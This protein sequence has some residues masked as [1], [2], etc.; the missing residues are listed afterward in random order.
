VL[1][2]SEESTGYTNGAVLFSPHLD[3]A[4]LSASCR[5]I[6]G[7]IR[8]VTIF[9][10]TPPPETELSYYDRLTGATSSHARALERWAEDDKAMKILNVETSRLGELDQQYR[11]APVDNSRLE[12]LVEPF[13]QN[14][15]EVW[16]PAGIGGHP[17][18]IATREAVTS[19]VPAE[20]EVYIYAD[21]PY[22]LLYGWPSWVNGEEEP[23]YLDVSFWLESELNSC[24]LNRRKLKPIPFKLDS[25]LKRRKEQAALCY[26]TQLPGMKLSP[27]DDHRWQE[28]L[29]YELAWKIDST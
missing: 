8:V 20:A 29:T 6:A 3:D 27:A 2:S 9:A 1:C 4:A 22:S 7:S 14:A 18:H 16:V 21:L 19:T 24:G 15:T 17:D 28:F 26:R 13:T 11:G 12:R 23:Q 5:L 10:G 25:G